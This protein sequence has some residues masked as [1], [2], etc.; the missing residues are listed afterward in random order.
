MLQA[1]A[2]KNLDP[3][4]WK[5]LFK[6]FLHFELVYIYIYVYS[7]CLFQRWFLLPP[8]KIPH[9][10]PNRTTLQ[11]LYEDYQELHPLEMPLECTIKQGE[12]G[13]GS[14]YS[15][16]WAQPALFSTLLGGRM[17]SAQLT[18]LGCQLGCRVIS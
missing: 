15:I 6:F 18:Q 12:V 3:W 2:N 4:F 14:V 8:E 5:H 16:A 10:H 17:L 1:N 11:W 13:H 9:F 7:D